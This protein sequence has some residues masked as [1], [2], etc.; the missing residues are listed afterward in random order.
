MTTVY[1]VIDKLIALFMLVMAGY[2]LRRKNIVSEGFSSGI[3]G[4]LTKVVLPVFFVMA[5]QLEYTPEKFHNGLK[6]YIFSIILILIATAIGFVTSKICGIKGA[7]RG[8]WIYSCIL[9]NHAFIGFPVMEVI[10][11]EEG[12]FYAAFA[13]A[14]LNTIAFSLG[15][16]IV[17][18]YAQDKSK[19]KSLS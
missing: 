13:N 4:F 17:G 19:K 5:M 12:L 8:I 11:G 18:L 14:A 1:A 2:F 15:V 10:F 3:S 7:D 9:P 16:V 6:V